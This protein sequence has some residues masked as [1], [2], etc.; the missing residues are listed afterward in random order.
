MANVPVPRIW[1]VGDLLQWTTEFFKKKNIDEPRLSAELLLAHAMQCQRMQLYMQYERVPAEGQLT[2][3]R[4][5]VKQRSEH[6]PVAYLI[7]K[8]W[9][10]SLEFAVT[11]E[12]LI[13]RPDTETLVEHTIQRLR[14]T[15]GW[16]APQILDLCTGSGCIA[17][18]LAKNMPNAH[19]VAVDISVKALEVARQNAQTHKVEE[20][21]TFLAGDLLVPVGGLLPP[22]KFHA[23]V[24]NPPYIPTGE[25]A[26]L[27][28]EVREHE[29]RMALDGGA[30][31]LDFHRR[32]LLEKH[33]SE[34]VTAVELLEAG[35]LVLL[36]IAY[37]EAEEAQKVFAQA[38]YLENIKLLRDAGGN[39]RCVIATKIK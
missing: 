15:P 13:P 17:V 10:F 27:M 6:V 20:R 7:G 19:V 11:R 24:S 33:G 1:T 35:A 22:R 34:G 12:V 21:V 37:N 5:M 18:A 30:D 8:S 3:F 9:F 16:E 23:L 32:I 38:G 29:P 31:G 4:E 26:G 2:G 36:E 14:Q 25:L 28:A 39:P